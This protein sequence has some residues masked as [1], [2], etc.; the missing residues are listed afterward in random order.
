MMVKVTGVSTNDLRR[1]AH[2]GHQGSHG[3]RVV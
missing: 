2:H 3:W 1:R